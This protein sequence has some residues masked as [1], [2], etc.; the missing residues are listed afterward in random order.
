[1]PLLQQPVYRYVD[2][3]RQRSHVSYVFSPEQCFRFHAP[4]TNSIK[5]LAFWRF[6]HEAK[7]RSRKNPPASS[8]TR[9]AVQSGSSRKST[10]I[11]LSPEEF[12]RRP[13]A[14]ALACRYPSSLT[15]LVLVPPDVRD[16]PH[17]FAAWDCTGPDGNRGRRYK[18]RYSA[19]EDCATMAREHNGGEL[20]SRWNN[21]TGDGTAWRRNFSGEA[22]QAQRK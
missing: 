9:R 17:P 10:S 7:R 8:P 5:T 4:R 15:P 21:D 2:P 22:R 12:F 20:P 3:L 6:I 14:A 16:A 11:N 1:M 13:I 19:P 18:N